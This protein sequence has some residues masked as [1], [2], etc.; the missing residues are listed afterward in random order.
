MKLTKVNL[1]KFSNKDNLKLF[2]KNFV[3]ALREST[4]FFP[5]LLPFFGGGAFLFLSFV[6]FC[7]LAFLRASPSKEKGKTLLFAFNLSS[8]FLAKKELFSR[9][10]SKKTLLKS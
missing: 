4:R 6:F 2:S 7:F 3:T 5:S 8:L 9:P 10:L 1:R